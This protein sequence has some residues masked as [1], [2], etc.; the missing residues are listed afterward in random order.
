MQGARDCELKKG[1]AVVSEKIKGAK[2]RDSLLPISLKTAED[3]KLAV[4][5]LRF[6]GSSNF[7]AF[8]RA[9]ALVFVPRGATLEAGEVA[10]ILYLP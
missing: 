10:Q 7:I 1:F 5:S 8:S 3:G 6:R 9:E 2:E 4:E